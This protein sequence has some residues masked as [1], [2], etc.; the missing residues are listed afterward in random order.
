MI[1]KLFRIDQSN[2]PSLEGQ[3]EKVSQEAVP[4]DLPLDLHEEPNER[5]DELMN[6][7]PPIPPQEVSVAP[8]NPLIDFLESNQGDWEESFMGQSDFTNGS[9]YYYLM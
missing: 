7:A 8:V 4:N 5:M 2:Q 3:S 1:A 6:F 9:G